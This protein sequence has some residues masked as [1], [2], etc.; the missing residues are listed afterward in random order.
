M[1]NNNFYQYPGFIEVVGFES[2]RSQAEDALQEM[3]DANESVDN[4]QSEEIAKNT[5][6]INAEVERS[7]AADAE[8]ESALAKEVEERKRMGGILNGKVADETSAREAA[9]IALQN[10]LNE[11]SSN[12]SNAFD[13]VSEQIEKEVSERIAADDEIKSSINAVDAAYKSADEALQKSI[14]EV[15][16]AY[17]V[18]DEEIKESINAVDAAYKAAD[19]ALQ[20]SIEDEKNSRMND[21]RSLKDSI[22]AVDAAYKAADVQLFDLFDK[23]EGNLNN[24]AADAKSYSIVKV[25]EGLSSNIK[26]A[27]K[28]VDEDNVQCGDVINVYKDSSLKEVKLEGEV[29][30]FTYILADGSESVVNVEISKFLSE[31]E[32]GTG[33]QVVDGV[34]SIKVNESN[35]HFLT[36]DSKGIKL[37]GVQLAIDSA[38]NEAMSH[39]TSLNEIEVSRAKAAEDI[40]NSSIVSEIERA[41]AAEK[42]NAD[43]LTAEKNARVDDTR[44]LK[45]SIKAIE[46][47]YKAADTNLNDLFDKLEGNL[48]DGIADVNSKIAAETTARSNADAAM[49]SSIDAIDASYKASIGDLTNTVKN[50]KDS[51]ETADSN[52]QSAI[53]KESKERV[54]NEKII[55]ESLNLLIASVENI[56]NDYKAAD[57]TL[58]TSVD[59]LSSSLLSIDAA[60]KAADAELRSAIDAEVAN[61]EANAKEIETIK[62]SV[63]SIEAAYKLA[64]EELRSAI[65]AI[66]A[67]YKAADDEVKGTVAKLDSN[68]L[69]L[70]NGYKL[71]DADLQLSIDS[72]V[73]E[74]IALNSLV[75]SLS[76]KISSIE[77]ELSLVKSENK[78]MKE[79]IDN[80]KVSVNTNDAVK[81]ISN[82]K[83]GDAV[84]LSLSSDLNFG[85]E[86]FTIPAGA[87]LT[88]DLNEH[89]ILNNVKNTILFRVNGELTI[90]GNGD[91]V[92]ESYFASANQGSKVTVNGGNYTASTTCFQSN[93]GELIVNDGYFTVNGGD[94]N[95]RYTLNFI[96][97]MK[98]IGTISVNGGTF[99]NYDPS[100]SYSE[101]PP[102]NFVAEG[103]DVVASIS[104]NGEVLYK[105][106]VP[107]V[108]SSAEDFSN[109]IASLPDN[110]T[111]YMKLENNLDFTSDEKIVINGDVCLNLNGKTITHNPINGDILFRVNGTLTIEGEGTFISNGYIASANEGSMVNVENGTFNANVTCFQSNGGI[112]NVN[113]G[114]FSSCNE[115]YGCKYTLNFIDSMKEVGQINVKGGSFVNYDPSNS[116]SE[117]PAMNFVAEGYK[118]EE[119]V[120]EGVTIYTVVKK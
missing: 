78:S 116:D 14:E 1:A 95:S 82:L 114:Y 39:A 4:S 28:L 72:E 115:T 15:E 107:S 2:M 113:G 54:E 42:M 57:A 90:N 32:F 26:E 96:D 89:K 102:M 11:V 71:A 109:V 60:Y 52:L 21:T 7:I 111:V 58:Q 5:E 64:D 55:S 19:E 119:S 48:N 112:L 118:V 84:T 66:D 68:L 16:A 3:V 104:D 85:E 18:A 45:D 40:L 108:V 88:I 31:S 86:I 43:A 25:S 27:Y 67:A 106:V 17:K 38:K 33:L 37:S 70:E 103:H 94:F 73:N 98:T 44:S 81:L 13:A 20:K 53:E 87:S 101:N 49:K 120:S 93:G 47:A 100:N 69:D 6:S 62:S 110:E 8:F 12:V 75:V 117:N 83:S 65:D 105:V 91:Y 80:L 79:E 59:S 34:V 76:E 41:K 77:E 46:T 10:A 36:I 35:E 63:S 74:R 61:G 51:Y 23:L 30:V 24:I 97:S 9:D 29:L 22:N 50:I 56:N 92:G 99:V